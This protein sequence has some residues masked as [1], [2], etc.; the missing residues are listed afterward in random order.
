MSEQQQASTYL[1]L[2][3]N[4]HIRLSVTVHRLHD[5]DLVFGRNGHL[6]GERELGT[7]HL[8]DALLDRLLLLEHGTRCL[9]VPKASLGHLE[10]LLQLRVDSGDRLGPLIPLHVDLVQE[11]G[12]GAL[13]LSPADRCQ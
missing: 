5:L 10:L 13:S 12:P 2:C 11:L 3:D 4:C 6:R 1:G 8:L 9:P 7:L